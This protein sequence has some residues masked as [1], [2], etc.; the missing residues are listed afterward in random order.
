MDPLLFKISITLLYLA[1]MVYITIVVLNRMSHEDP[2]DY[3]IQERKWWAT[4]LCSPL[5]PM[6]G[7]FFWDA[8]K[9]VPCA[10]RR[11]EYEKGENCDYPY[12]SSKEYV[13]MRSMKKSIAD[14]FFDRWLVNEVSRDPEMDNSK[15]WGTTFFVDWLE[16]CVTSELIDFNRGIEKWV[17]T[18][19][20]KNKRNYVLK[21]LKEWYPELY[22]RSDRYV[23]KSALRLLFHHSLYKALRES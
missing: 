13:V 1:S 20:V 5:Y 10:I 16:M 12:Y 7:I 3:L 14:Y 18:N 8:W 19:I 22:R 4:I 23:P 17:E 2:Y 9:W 6:I 11:S 15:I 21:A